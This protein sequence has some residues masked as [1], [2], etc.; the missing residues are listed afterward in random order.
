MGKRD[1]LLLVKSG[2]GELIKETGTAV[3]A[4]PRDTFPSP[5]PITV[6]PNQ[7]AKL[8]QQAGHCFKAFATIIDVDIIP[9]SQTRKPRHKTLLKP[10][11]V[12]GADIR[13]PDGLTR[14]STLTSPALGGS[15][16]AAFS[17]Y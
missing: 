9:I 1:P 7:I 15:E 17:R 14:Q 13:K 6:L 3:G 16:A 12:A 8:L 10:M 11:Q 2:D 5:A 4:A